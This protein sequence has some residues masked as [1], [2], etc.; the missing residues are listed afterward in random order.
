MRPSKRS[1][2]MSTPREKRSTP[3]RRR[4]PP[5]QP[6]PNL[7]FQI[8]HLPCLR[9]GRPAVPVI[10]V[11]FV[12]GP[13]ASIFSC[14]LCQGTH[15]LSVSSAS[16]TF[17]VCYQ[18]YT[19]RYPPEYYEVEAPPI[20]RVRA[21]RHSGDEPDNDAF[22]G[23][24]VIPLR[25][26]HFLRSEV[27]TLWR[28]SN[29]RCHICDRE[30]TVEQRGARGW[31]IDHLIPH[32]GGGL[33]VERLPNFR[34]ACARCNLKKGTGYAEARIRLGLRALVEL[35]ARYR[36][37]SQRSPR[38]KVHGLTSACSR[39]PSAAVI[40]RVWRLMTTLDARHRFLQVRRRRDE[41]R[42]SRTRIFNR[43]CAS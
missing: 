37:Y 9:C 1:K 41:L 17:V 30:W 16:S 25:K 24:I 6:A 2:R 21:G 28:A 39:W 23:P 4:R 36:D 8:V 42:G 29:G 20:V 13:S 5:R 27:Q 34:V 32:I 11:R 3:G 19:L 40:L 38:S 12:I 22:S 15:Y 14:R 35:L 33:D 10:P 31:H 43:C 26:R 7:A 18:R